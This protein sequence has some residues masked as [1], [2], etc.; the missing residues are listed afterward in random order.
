MISFV[1]L[2]WLL[3]YISPIVK[4]LLTIRRIRISLNKLVNFVAVYGN[5]TP[6]FRPEKDVYNNELTALL[7]YY[8]VISEFVSS[9]KLSYRQTEETIY[10]NAR[11]I[12]PDLQMQMNEFRH[13]LIRSLNPLVSARE[14]VLL[15][16]RALQELGFR[17][18]RIS[19]VFLNITG[20]TVSYLLGM[21]QPEIKALLIVLFEKLIA[22]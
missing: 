1:V 13:K 7:R 18:G 3:S 5:S 20:W 22:A 10:Q 4:C 16:V 12:I 8:P 11:K 17:P 14:L 21:F 15:P 2:L 19:S 6:Y 9:P